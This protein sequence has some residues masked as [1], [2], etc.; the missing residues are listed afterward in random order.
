MNQ[1]GGATPRMPPRTRHTAGHDTPSGRPPPTRQVVPLDVGALLG[2]A[3][4]LPTCA[5]CL[6]RLDPSISGIFTIVCNHQFHCDCLRRWADSSC[7]V[8]RHVQARRR[9]HDGEFRITND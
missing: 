9:S 5:V 3:V 2:E 8:C 1:L 4:E 7:P 6:E